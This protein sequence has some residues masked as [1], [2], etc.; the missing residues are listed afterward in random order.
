MI[1]QDWWWPCKL[2]DGWAF[3]TS[4]FFFNFFLRWWMICQH[5]KATSLVHTHHL[6]HQASAW[7]D[8]K[9]ARKK[10]ELCSP[11]TLNQ[12]EDGWCLPSYPTPS[13][14]F[15][16]NHVFMLQSAG[17]GCFVQLAT[18]ALRHVVLKPQEQMSQ[19]PTSRDSPQSLPLRISFCSSIWSL[20]VQGEQMVTFKSS[21]HLSCMVV[22]KDKVMNEIGCYALYHHSSVWCMFI[23][24]SEKTIVLRKRVFFFCFSCNILFYIRNLCQPF[25]LTWPPLV[26]HH[27]QLCGRLEL[28]GEEIT[29]NGVRY[30]S[31]A[32]K[33]LPW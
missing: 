5:A 25:P 13:K 29:R 20:L 2:L 23:S 33:Q 26:G 1:A 22:G 15:L 21:A 18:H 11:R 7:R 19:L 10:K 8:H 16:T 4:F 31:I 28:P 6:L 12:I 32:C 27:L 3:S 30:K 17:W 9:S 24:P 14:I